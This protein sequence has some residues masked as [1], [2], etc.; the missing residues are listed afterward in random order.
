LEILLLLLLVLMAGIL[1]VPGFLKE[2][3]LDSP[4]ETVSDFRRGMTALA[5]STHNYKPSRQYMYSRSTDPEPYVNV[6]RSHY[7][8]QLDEHGEDFVPYPT[9]RR[10][11]EMEARRNRVIAILLVCALATGIMAIIP[12][13]KWVIPIHIVMLVILAGYIALAILVPHAERRR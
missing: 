5:V 13:L 1:F 9:A 3:T 12:T 6:R 11:Q 2:R 7:T 4:V 10:H 8:E